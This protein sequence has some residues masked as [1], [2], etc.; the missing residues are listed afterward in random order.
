M[1]TLEDVWYSNINPHE[2]FLEDNEKLKELLPIMAKDREKLSA[3]LSSEQIEWLE[4]YDDIIN[5][6]HSNAEVEAFKHGFRLATAL[7][8][9]ST[10]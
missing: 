3:R 10:A 6:M 4:K 7:F 1:I 8:I 2:Q 9:E 5:E